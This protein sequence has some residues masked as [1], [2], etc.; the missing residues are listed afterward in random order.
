MNTTSLLQYFNRIVQLNEPEIAAV[1]KLFVPHMLKKGEL[2][3]GEG[4]PC[5]HI[6]FVNSG[7]F[8]FFITP[9][10]EDVTTLL[11]G[12]G[13]FISS[14]AGFLGRTPAPE[15][16]QAV[17]DA[18]TFLIS[19]DDLQKLYV[20]HPRFERIGRII[21]ENYFI[22]KDRRLISFIKDS[23][24]DRYRHLLN[25][26]PDYLQ[27]IPLQYIASALGVKPE[28][29]SRIRSRIIS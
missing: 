3:V 14:F 5:D 28:T 16:V 25:H 21:I 19:Y 1:G 4:Q 6:A 12:P 18:E 17:T 27:N 13:E 26:Y 11:S 8:R 23:A 10:I 2:L 24:E 9:D 7:Y 15:S 22:K 20:E 29:L